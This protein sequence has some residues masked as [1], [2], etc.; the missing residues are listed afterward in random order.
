MNYKQIKVDHLVNTITKKDNLFNGNYTV[1][2]YQNCEFG[3]KYCDSTFEP[4]IYIKY[5]ACEVFKKEI[6]NLEKGVIIVGSVHDPYQK[7]EEKH[8]I[9]RCLLQTILKN[10]FPCHILTKSKLVLRDIDLLSK[11]DNCRV[12]ISILSTNDEIS[13]TFEKNLPATSER[14]NL[15]KTLQENNIDSGIAVMPFLP[16]IV[17]NDIYDIVK[18]AKENNASYIL[19]KPLELKGDQKQFFLDNLKET[20]PEH[21]SKYEQTYKNNITPDETYYERLTSNFKKVCKEF[22]IKNRV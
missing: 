12:T 7:A 19:Y 8:L 14:F 16:F 5:N 10:D 11:I 3:C 9:T 20:F 2:P 22:D 15:V 17:E 21:V 4:I 18:S 1:D 13:N 6:K